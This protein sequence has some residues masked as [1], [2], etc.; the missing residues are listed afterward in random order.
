MVVLVQRVD[1]VRLVLQNNFWIN[2]GEIEGDGE[3][4]DNNC[5]EH[6]FNGWSFSYGG[7]KRNNDPRPLTPSTP[8]VVSAQEK[9]VA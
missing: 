4:N 5:F 3:D 2:E 1:I 9:I 7:T 8:T 6:D